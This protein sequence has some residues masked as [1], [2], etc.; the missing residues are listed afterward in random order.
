M[1]QTNNLEA[2]K[3]ELLAKI[4]S[5]ATAGDL[6]QVAAL[7]RELTHFSRAVKVEADKTTESERNT[8]VETLATALASRE[9][10]NATQTALRQSAISIIVRRTD[11]GL[12][13]GRAS[14]AA[15]AVYDTLMPTIE[16]HISKVA[17]IK[18]VEVI[19]T[20]D[21]TP[22]V[23]VFTT[24]RASKPRTPGTDSSNY[25]AR[26]WILNGQQHKLAEAF[27][28]VATPEE[29]AKFDAIPDDQNKGNNQYAMKV[30]VVKAAGYTPG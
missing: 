1:A 10:R 22:R 9:V 24:S 19:I 14:V 17:S 23:E 15:S 11:T 18:R 6:D 26:G 2:R 25:G 8:A 29:M 28:K 13:D 3:T 5:A 20:K 7:G 12:D 21:G 4:Q 27:D 30:K 16:E